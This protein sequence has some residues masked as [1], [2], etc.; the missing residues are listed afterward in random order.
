MANVRSFTDY[1]NNLK[2]HPLRSISNKKAPWSPTLS[3]LILFSRVFQLFVR[4]E[5]EIE[6]A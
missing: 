5:N 2:R 3:S 6:F 4:S 1:Q